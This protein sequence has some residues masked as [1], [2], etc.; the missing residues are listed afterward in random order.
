[1][2]SLE[3]R[4]AGVHPNA[5]KKVRPNAKYVSD[6]L[7]EYFLERDK[8]GYWHIK[9]YKGGKLPDKLQTAYTSFAVAER[10]LI[11]HLEYTNKWGRAIYP[12]GK[13]RNQQTLPN[14]R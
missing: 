10:D 13:S 1:M 3:D 2:V 6:G 5:R 4:L 7:T 12:D 11:A 9:R 14:V 8:N